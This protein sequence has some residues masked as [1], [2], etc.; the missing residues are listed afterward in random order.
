MGRSNVLVSMTFL[1]LA[2][3][4]ASRPAP[5]PRA[6]PAPAP[7]PV[8][9]PPPVL[10]PAPAPDWPDRP[11]T[12]GEWSYDEGAARA[13]F[14]A[15]DGAAFALRCDRSARRI[16]IDRENGAGAMTIRTT[17]AERRFAEAR[18]ALPATEPLLD[19]IAFSRG[20]FLVETD[21]QIMVI[22]A[23]PEPA[24]AVEDCRS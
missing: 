14:T 22:P 4:C 3:G 20:R 6:A 13:R 16:L 9:T 12:P 1:L 17:A 2:A 11:L 21:G 18:A 24:K 7:P 23:W 15:A 10:A 19:A 5:A 8:A